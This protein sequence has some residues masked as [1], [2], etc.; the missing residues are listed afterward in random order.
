MADQFKGPLSEHELKEM[1]RKA[2]EAASFD[3]AKK[4]LAK[5]FD[6]AVV[7]KY[8]KLD[9]EVIRSLAEPE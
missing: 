5:G 9:V 4:M 2:L 8:T 1:R 3:M 7:A 6:P